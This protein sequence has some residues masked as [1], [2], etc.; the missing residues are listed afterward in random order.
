MELFLYIGEYAKSVYGKEGGIIKIN[1]KYFEEGFNKK[2]TA[3]VAEA[4]RIFKQTHGHDKGAVI[5]VP[6]L[7][8]D[9]SGKHI[10]E[11]KKDFEPVLEAGNG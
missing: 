10:K 2:I 9:E 6:Y 4:T 11:F 5:I 8:Y 3:A 7:Q 1:K